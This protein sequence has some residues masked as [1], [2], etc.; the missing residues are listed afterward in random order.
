M[1]QVIRYSKRHGTESNG[2]CFGHDISV[3][4]RDVKEPVSQTTYESHNK[5]ASAVCDASD[6]TTKR[7]GSIALPKTDL[8]E[9]D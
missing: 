2:V 7:P 3:T 9:P 1:H 6:T 4:Q 8:M 5:L